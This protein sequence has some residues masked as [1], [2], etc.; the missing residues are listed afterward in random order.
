MHKPLPGSSP[1]F[2]ARTVA[3]ANDAIHLDAIDPVWCDFTDCRLDRIAAGAAT[4]LGWAD[5]AVLSNGDYRGTSLK[6]LAG[7]FT[8]EH[9]NVTHAELDRD[10]MTL[11]ECEESALFPQ[12]RVSPVICS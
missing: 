10:R 8:I 12:D 7:H 11:H 4:L 6:G 9:S 2:P 1:E 5:G 3:Q